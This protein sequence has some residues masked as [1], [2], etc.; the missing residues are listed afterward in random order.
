MVTIDLIVSIALIMG[1]ALFANAVLVWAITVGVST[2][3][4][5]DIRVAIGIDVIVSTAAIVRPLRTLIIRADT[6][7]G[8]AALLSV[9]GAGMV[10]FVVRPAKTNEP[11][12]W[13]S[14]VGKEPYQTI[15]NNQN[16]EENKQGF[17]ETLHKFENQQEQHQ[18]K[19]PGSYVVE[20][21]VFLEKFHGVCLRTYS[22]GST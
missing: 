9:V 7:S 6:V 22:N 12:N 5:R 13:L 1:V 4:I 21:C 8:P 19:D 16:P 17:G 15:T 3:V 11:G 18:H 10:F 2:A 14:D 20:K